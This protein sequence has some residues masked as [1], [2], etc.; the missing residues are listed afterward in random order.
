M[1]V[2]LYHPSAEANVKPCVL[3]GRFDVSYSKDT[4]TKPSDTATVE[5]TET[6]IEDLPDGPV[7]RVFQH[8][9][10]HGT[11]TET[12]VAEMLG[13]PREQ[14]RFARNFEKYA[15]SA[16]FTARI[17]VVS[18]VKRYVREGVTS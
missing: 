14:R 3:K 8:L 17:D 5:I 4:A 11:V 10:R 7:R 12:E 9:S 13:S 16:P 15:A 1:Q 2:E 18:G 6:W